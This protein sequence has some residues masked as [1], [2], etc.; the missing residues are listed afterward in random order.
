MLFELDPHCV[1]GTEVISIRFRGSH[2]INS[3]LKQ[4]WEGKL[5]EYIYLNDHMITAK[6]QIHS[7]ASFHEHS[8]AN[9]Y[10]MLI[11]SDDSQ[12]IR[13]VCEKERLFI[14]SPNKD[15]TKIARAN[16]VRAWA[17]AESEPFE[18]AHA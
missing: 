10:K 12:L 9:M 18:D 17:P 4:I 6:P 13:N 15:I 5:R 11:L 1:S 7:M 14:F 3:E 2:W 8:V 16:R